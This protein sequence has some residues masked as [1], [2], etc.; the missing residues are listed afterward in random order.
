MNRGTAAIVA[1]EIAATAAVQASGLGGIYAT[2]GAIAVVVVTGGFL[3]L[4]PRPT[5]PERLRAFVAERRA[6]APPADDETGCAD[7]ELDTS[8]CFQ[9]RYG[10]A[11]KAETQRLVAGGIIGAREQQR[12]NAPADL[13]A[14]EHLADRL[15]ELDGASA[16]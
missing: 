2:C 1:L 15:A 4:Q 10:P 12:L 9:R 11:V 14:I 16:R 8:E 13:P 6:S 7:F 5:L 3:F